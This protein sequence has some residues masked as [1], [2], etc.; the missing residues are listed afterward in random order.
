M[1]TLAEV[2]QQIKALGDTDTFGTKKEIKCLPDIM[3]DDETVLGLTSGLMDGNTWLIVCTER[4]V[5]FLDKGMIYGLKQRETALEKINSIE[6]K[7]GMV[8][9]S[10]TI[11]DGASG[12]QI[13]NAMKPT[14][15]PFVDAVNNAIAKMK[16]GNTPAAAPAAP[17]PAADEDDVVSRL[18]RL[19]AL[20]ERGILT[21][22]EFLAQKAK[23]LA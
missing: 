5:I 19:A 13:K 2:Q 18:E 16:A 14:V 20:K 6:H 9:G 17:A 7:L 1:P 3:Y 12:M 4:R 21:D 8:F 11:W 15:K 22:D 23:I 10:I